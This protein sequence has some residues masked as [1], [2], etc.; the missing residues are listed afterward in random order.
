[1]GDEDFEDE[2]VRHLVVV[3]DEEQ[4]SVWVEAR[5]VPAGWRAVGSAGS[6]ARCLDDIAAV[7]TDMR[8]ASL[9]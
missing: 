6:K 8:P 7:W 9:R 2:A 1:M 3:N 5:P 4:Y